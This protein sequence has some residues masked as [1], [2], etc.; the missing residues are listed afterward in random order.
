VSVARLYWESSGLVSIDL[1]SG[2][3]D[4]NDIGV[5]VVGLGSVADDRSSDEVFW[6]LGFFGLR[7]LGG[8]VVLAAL[9]LVAH[10]GGCG[11]WEVLSDVVGGKKW[12]CGKMPFIDC[13]NP[14]GC[15]W[16]KTRGMQELDEFCGAGGCGG[17]ICGWFVGNGY[18]FVGRVSVGWVG[19]LEVE[20]P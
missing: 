1:A 17:C 12:P 2:W 16:R 6:N 18:G 4:I 7:C 10:G 15:C 11:L 3:R 14:S 13:L 9:V 8:S 19:G 20:V 5:D